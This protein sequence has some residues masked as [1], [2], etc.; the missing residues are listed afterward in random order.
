LEEAK[1]LEWREFESETQRVRE[2][3]LRAERERESAEREKDTWVTVGFG[4]T[5]CVC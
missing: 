1:Q 4:W 3:S 5:V 2:D